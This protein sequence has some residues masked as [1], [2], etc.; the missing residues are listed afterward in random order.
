MVAV[1]TME[2]E[3]AK[4]PHRERE[5]LVGERTR[6]VN[7]MKGALAQL[8]IRGF[9]PKLRKAPQ[10]LGGLLTPEDLPI[11]SNSLDQFRRD[12]ARLEKL[13][14]EIAAIEQARPERV[15]QA[16]ATGPHAIVRLLAG[17]LGL[18]VETA[19]MLVV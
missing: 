1:P 3:D 9:K 6:I 2:E 12:L 8:G 5:S 10:R 15:K 18:G 11:P 7:R 16:P 14:E 19:D 13:W 17:I 4:R